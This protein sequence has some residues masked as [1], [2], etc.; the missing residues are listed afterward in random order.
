MPPRSTPTARQERLGT[1][2]RKMREA[3][4]VSARDAAKLLGVDPAKISHIEAGRVGVSEERLRRLAAFYQCGDEAL[5]DAL[6]AMTYEQRGQ[7]WWEDYR[8]ILPAPLRDLAEM[9]HHA[10]FLR[11]IQITH[12]PGT[13][14]TED[15][16]RTVFTYAFPPLP[17]ADMEARLAHR[18]ERQK[19]LHRD[20]PPPFDALIHETALRMRFGGRKVTRAQLE[21]L[22][23]L[24]EHP[25]ITVRVIP[26]EVEDP[27]GSGHAMHYTGGPV[28]QLDTVQID[29]AL[30]MDFLHAESRL[31]RCRMLFEAV[32]GAALSKSASRDLI[33]SVIREL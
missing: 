6:A 14:Q 24:S 29:T 4:A 15:Y 27:I 21:H 2:L 13:F 12:F 19:I 23:K 7:G 16:A 1:E 22:Q 10:T 17:Q 33:H 20:E 31:K 32:K 11:T 26:F 9:E 28:P 25:N 5:I 18:M 8:G 30:G 3:A